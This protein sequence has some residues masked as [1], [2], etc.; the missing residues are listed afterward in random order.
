MPLDI[1][2]STIVQQCFRA[3]ET[4]LPS[5]LDD[6]SKHARDAKEQYPIALEIA[7]EANDWSFAS[8]QVSLPPVSLPDGVAEDADM[9]VCYKLPTDCVRLMEVVDPD[10]IWRLDEGR[11]IRADAEGGLVIRYTRKIDSEDRLPATFRTAVAM[12]LAVL[13]APSYV[14]T[15]SR[16]DR[17][18]S[19]A[20]DMLNQA[21][22][23]DKRSA[24]SSRWD[25]LERKSDWASEATR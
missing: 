24:S 9:P 18:A 20:G 4:T 7:L 14:R 11:L 12:Q 19:A 17:L 1:A 2:T 8:R 13:L 25:G 21:K 3:L 22:S 15:Q 10:T 5:S 23:A 6:N 16:R